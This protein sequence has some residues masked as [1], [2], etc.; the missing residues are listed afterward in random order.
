M[1]DQDPYEMAAAQAAGGAAD[2]GAVAGDD[3]Y[4][5][6]EAAAPSGRATR[7]IRKRVVEAVNG[8]PQDIR[9][10][11]QKSG[12][13]AQ[14]VIRNVP[15]VYGGPYIR[16][17]EAG[18]NR[19][20]ERLDESVLA[21][22][23][24][25]P[26]QNPYFAPAVATVLGGMIPRPSMLVDPAQMALMVG[27]KMALNAVRPRSAPS[28][29]ATPEAPEVV[30][31]PPEPPA[32]A[33]AEPPVPKFTVIEPRGTP[34][35]K[36]GPLVLEKATPQMLQARAGELGQALRMREDAVREAVAAGDKKNAAFERKVA[37]GIKAEQQAVFAELAKRREAPRPAP[38]VAPEPAQAPIGNTRST[39]PFLEPQELP[40]P[41]E[42]PL[43]PAATALPE[44]TQAK[45]E[46]IMDA[47][48][49]ITKAVKALRDD[50]QKGGQELSPE[51]R[52]A[53]KAI[54]D[55][56][57][58]AAP[59]RREH[60]VAGASPDAAMKE[61]GLGVI[62]DTI[63]DGSLQAAKHSRERLQQV[64]P[65]LDAAE[66][67]SGS[68]PHAEALYRILDGN[69][70]EAAAASAKKAGVDLVKTRAAASGI[71]EILVSIAQELGL[72]PERMVKDYIKHMRDLE[73]G[74]HVSPFGDVEGPGSIRA[75]SLEY[76][77]KGGRPYTMDPIRSLESYIN[78]AYRKKYLAGAVDATKVML[79]RVNMSDT[80]KKVVND[81]INAVTRERTPGERQGGAFIQRNLLR[82]LSAVVNAIP[83]KVTVGGRTMEVP[84]LGRMQEWAKDML[85]ADPAD[86]LRGFN[87][88]TKGGVNWGRIHLNP[89]AQWHIQL[90][91]LDTAIH[92]GIR[93]TIKG[94][95]DAVA[96]SIGKAP[97]LEAEF[98]ETGMRAINEQ[99]ALY[100]AQL[101]TVADRY[102]RADKW[103]S[104]VTRMNELNT[105]KV[106]YF[107]SR[108]KW[109]ESHP[110]DIEGAK[111]AGLEGIKRTQPIFHPAFTPTGL[112]TP[113][114][115]TLAQYAQHTLKKGELYKN[116]LR[117]AATD[118]AAALRMAAVWGAMYALY[119]KEDRS[120][121]SNV[122][123][124]AARVMLPGVSPAVQLYMASRDPY[125][126]AGKMGQVVK[127]TMVPP[128]LRRG[129]E[130][131]KEFVKHLVQ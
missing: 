53:Y 35:P 121:A 83:N 110:G 44:G 67:S 57:P 118:P 9:D 111:A 85:A 18:A 94:F 42:P 127:D 91:S 82:P 22:A 28:V 122:V 54:V 93:N 112:T 128:G 51:E 48:A 13:F 130:K 129:A 108:R 88:T 104:A 126:A 124:T 19:L 10:V 4:A 21:G 40:A 3:P 32:P 99:F 120:V 2:A 16:A 52:Q 131:A 125:N 75:G 33:P 107:A 7:S 68:G 55:Q 96:T 95:K 30:P 113:V 115:R 38:A 64:Q 92:A 61:M 31:V 12:E 20:G 47:D 26:N 109:L 29:L 87:R 50:A 66:V 15:D 43:P 63:A 74:T 5:A 78:Q 90:S 56:A 117:N 80:A 100:D 11:F 70:D 46:V 37:K 79:D 14:G 41:E 27:P 123:N 60:S 17:M 58:T 34:E 116:T 39:G 71:R 6:A 81:Y 84:V 65:F 23:E 45:F 49:K 1:P 77:R 97:E 62:E 98:N 114:G 103:V 72:P 8:I 36:V 73:Q 89:H 105:K 86:V 106:A 69:L 102:S 119:A 59:W 101:E 24:Q 76:S 25:N